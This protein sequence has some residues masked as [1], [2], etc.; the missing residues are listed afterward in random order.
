MR[1]LSDFKIDNVIEKYFDENSD[2]S[3]HIKNIITDPSFKMLISFFGIITFFYFSNWFVCDIFGLFVPAFLIID[4][5]HNNNITQIINISKHYF[6]YSHAYFIG[7][8]FRSLPFYHSILLGYLM[9]II[10]ID[11]F[12]KITELFYDLLL[13]TDTTI[14]EHIKKIYNDTQIK[15]IDHLQK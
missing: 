2:S 14:C 9:Y 7:L 1:I 12:G 15:L 10:F 11:R 8:F 3:K 5:L 6:I 13:I 4:N